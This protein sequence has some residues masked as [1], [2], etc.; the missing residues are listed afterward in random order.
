M[1]AHYIANFFAGAFLCNCIPHLVSSL[2]GEPFPSPFAKPP[3]VGDSSP[4]VNFLWSFF[5]L[6]VGLV[7]LWRAPFIL[8]P[9]AGCGLFLAGCLAMGF[10]TSHHFGKVWR[11]KHFMGD[12]TLGN[13]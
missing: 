9:N 8:G 1:I 13:R 7:L 4:L 10:S 12:K 11:D 5:N 2:R 6:L 3:G